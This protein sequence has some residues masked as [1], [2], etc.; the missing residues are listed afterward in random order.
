[1]ILSFGCVRALIR[2]SLYLFNPKA[3][4]A[5][6][7]YDI[8]FRMFTYPPY[9][10]G[11]PLVPE[12]ALQPL[13]LTSTAQSS[14]SRHLLSD[15]FCPTRFL[16]PSSPPPPPP[17]PPPEDKSWLP[18]PAAASPANALQ[19]RVQVYDIE[20]SALRSLHCFR[21]LRWG[22]GPLPLIHATIDPTRPP[23]TDPEWH[24]PQL[25]MEESAAARADSDAAPIASEFDEWAGAA[26]LYQRYVMQ[27]LYGLP[28]RPAAVRAAQAVEQRQFPPAQAEWARLRAGPE[29]DGASCGTAH[30]PPLRTIRVLIVSRDN[31]T[32]RAIWN[33]PLLKSAFR[34]RYTNLHIESCCTWKHG[35]H[36]AQRPWRC[37][38][39]S[40]S[41]TDP[42]LIDLH[43]AAELIAFVHS[44]DILI[45]PHGAGLTNGLYLPAGGVI[46]QLKAAYG[47]AA[48]FA[49]VAKV[50]WHE[51][52][53]SDSLEPLVW[54]SDTLVDEDGRAVPIG[55]RLTSPF[56]ERFADAVMERWLGRYPN[57]T[58]RIDS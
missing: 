39:S 43:S 26:L 48:L 2:Q 28:M 54:H 45:G 17:P 9:R 32:S 42:R 58:Q 5:L 34:D 56:C 33:Y 25:G 11:K 10:N 21:N 4:Q 12:P 20:G 30:H 31:D 7:L 18:P 22:R 38:P 52:V 41:S 46:G 6:P 3:A 51:H 19:A 57:T 44:F 15:Y 53:L 23:P 36:R 16:R 8:V 49:N 29:A 40:T 35:V 14:A 13:L 37:A 55:Y 1:M 50:M 27:D 47:E 24:S